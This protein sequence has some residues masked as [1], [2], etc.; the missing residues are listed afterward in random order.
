MD[1]LLCWYPL[2]VMS[3]TSR[4]NDPHRIPV[5]QRSLILFARWRF[6]CLSPDRASSG[7]SGQTA[8]CCLASA[9]SHSDVLTS[10]LVISRRCVPRRARYI[11]CNALHRLSCENHTI[12]SAWFFVL[13]FWLLDWRFLLLRTRTYKFYSFFHKALY[14]LVLFWWRVCRPE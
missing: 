14:M 2:V 12:Q 6:P 3:A 10:G 9:C 7:G 13:Y 5:L 8:Q 11:S 4:S 1:G